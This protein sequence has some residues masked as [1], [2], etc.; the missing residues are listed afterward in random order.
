M[1]HRG[2][3]ASAASTPRAWGQ[4]GKI[5]NEHQRMSKTMPAPAA[6][7]TE[8]SGRGSIGGLNKQIFA[9]KLR[10]GAVMAIMKQKR[11]VAA[12]IGNVWRW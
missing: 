9:A 4:H 5:S 3:A 8:R 12:D 7:E 1:R 2:Q 11:N 10:G 6:S